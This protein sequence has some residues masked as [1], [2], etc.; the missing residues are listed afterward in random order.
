MNRTNRYLKTIKS[1]FKKFKRN[2]PKDKPFDENIFYDACR[3]LKEKREHYGL[4]R[5]QLA[6]KTK[7]STTV[8]EAIENGWSNQLPERT[9]LMSMLTILENELGL[10]KGSLN[11]ILRENYNRKRSNISTFSTGNI[12]LLT[13]WQGGL[14]YIIFML[15]FIFLLNQSQKNIA[16]KHMVTVQPI[17]E[18]KLKKNLSN[19]KA[20]KNIINFNKLKKDYYLNGSSNILSNL[21]KDFKVKSSQG[22]L[23]LKLQQSKTIIINNGTKDIIKITN[24]KGP[25]TLYLMTPATLR[26]V[27]EL[28]TGEVIIWRGRVI[29]NTSI[30]NGIYQLKSLF[31][32]QTD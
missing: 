31:D 4:K 6:L 28:T 17:I 7:I 27:P 20:D 18:T 10:N 1:L 21:Y 30:K 26:I 8:L 2:E 12:E 29:S 9:Y 25:I 13:S 16:K 15:T 22:K 3:L 11:P 32:T 19:T 23:D 5:T 24:T 14:L